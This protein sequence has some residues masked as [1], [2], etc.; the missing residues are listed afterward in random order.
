MRKRIGILFTGV[1]VTGCTDRFLVRVDSLQLLFH[2]RQVVVRRSLTKVIMSSVKM[3]FDVMKAFNENVLPVSEN[4][5]TKYPYPKHQTNQVKRTLCIFVELKEED[6]FPIE[7]PRK[8]LR[9]NVC[10]L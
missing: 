7:A 8:V 3:Y 2:R 5:S 9:Q 1:Y 10:N 4:I 6:V